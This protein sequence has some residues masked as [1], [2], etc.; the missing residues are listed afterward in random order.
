MTRSGCMS[1]ICIVMLLIVFSGCAS[2]GNTG[3]TIG[4]S[5]QQ[6]TDSDDP[7]ADGDGSTDNDVDTDGD[8]D[9]DDDT[10]TNDQ[11]EET[12]ELCSSNT[13]DETDH[14]VCD[15]ETGHCICDTGFCDI[16]AVCVADGT[17]N[18]EHACLV[19]D[20]T[21]MKND[22]TLHEVDFECRAS[23][24]EC[25][26]AEVCDGIDEDC[27]VDTFV[28]DGEICNDDSNACNGVS[29]CV[30]GSCNETTAP[31]ICTASDDCHVAGACDIASGI[32]TNP[33][34]S[35]GTSCGEDNTD[36]CVSGICKDCYDALGCTDYAEDDNPCTDLSC[37]ANTCTDTNDNENTC[38]LD[39]ECTNDHCV[40]GS[41][42]V[43]TVTTGCLIDGNC[44]AE[45]TSQDT[46]GCVACDP[47]NDDR[48]WSNMDG[49]TCAVTDDGRPCTDNVCNGGVCVAVNDDTNPCTDEIG[50]TQTACSSGDCVVSGTNAGCYIAEACF[51]EGTTETASG[52]GTCRIC[53]SVSAWNAW[54]TK[55]S[56]N[57]NDANACTHTD[58]CGTGGICSGTTYSCNDHGTCNSEDDFCT[59]ATGYAGDYCTECAQGYSDY[60]NCQLIPTPSF[61]SITAGTF[62]MGSP[63]GDCPEGYP[64]A[65]TEELGRF[66]NETLHQVTLTYDFELNRYE[67]TEKEFEALTGWNAMDTYYSECANGCG[68]DHPIKYVSW[69]DTLAYANRL[70]LNA[71][72]PTC[73]ALTAVECKY[74]GS[75]GTDYMDCFDDDLTYGGIE[76]A[77]VTLADGVEKP[78][79][80]E[81]YRLPTEA[82]WEYAIR[83]GNQYTA[84]YQND[85]NDGTITQQYCVPVDSNLD[86]IGWFCGNNGN[87]E[88]PDYGTKP[89]GTKE[90]NDWDLYDMS[91]NLAE[92]TWNFNQSSYEDDVATDP[93]G[94]SSGTSHVVRGG[95]WSNGAKSCRS[96]TRTS[97]SPSYRG[98]GVGFRLCRSLH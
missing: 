79:D 21:M 41:C 81:G 9:A 39:H 7:I 16:N 17:N 59:C 35:D 85:E 24:G 12:D 38:D 28:A 37:V 6:T 47:D 25:D 88:T 71:E 29:T 4:D 13:C 19:C 93:I 80:C 95:F 44:V 46:D 42:V 82:E 83:A 73:Y 30:S 34:A 60:P 66:S 84:F 67:I 31:V 87:P 45:G 26:I 68:D 1:G 77:T 78:Q 96:A 2:E 5:D 98:Y 48:G 90:P 8:G 62:W 94:Q 57:C 86:R 72:R 49:A 32:C 61:V 52:D 10:V 58:I 11:E 97:G 76:S 18:P 23:A 53:E 40:D 92:W 27:P 50:C 22:W 65:C 54:T 33:N 56:G 51:D 20:S 43:E 14:R 89:V 36:Q 75:V 63:D 64:G 91:G 74:G 55:E 69:Y 15:A 3:S 70:S